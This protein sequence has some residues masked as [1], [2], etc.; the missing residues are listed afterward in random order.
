MKTRTWLVFIGLKVLEVIAYA[1]FMWLLWW[2]RTLDILVW[3][4]CGVVVVAFAMFVCYFA[5]QGV[6]EFIK[7]N[8]KLAKKITKERA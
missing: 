2:L 3:I 1:G 7:F 8:I 5:T 4:V 6:W